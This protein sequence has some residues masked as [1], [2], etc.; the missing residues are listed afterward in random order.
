MRLQINN[1]RNEVRTPVTGNIET[2]TFV[3]FR[4]YRFAETAPQVFSFIPANATFRLARC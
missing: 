4:K 2:T 3:E 1:P